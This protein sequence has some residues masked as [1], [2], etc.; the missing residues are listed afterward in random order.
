M[1]V[2][3]QNYGGRGGRPMRGGRN[4]MGRSGKPQC[5]DYNGNKTKFNE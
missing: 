5:R 4:G 1:P 2:T 3:G